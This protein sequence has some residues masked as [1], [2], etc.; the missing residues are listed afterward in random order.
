MQN[1]S[2]ALI[3]TLQISPTIH[4]NDETTLNFSTNQET[5][6]SRSAGN[7]LKHYLHNYILIYP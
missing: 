1:T 6:E 4:M 2:I 3:Q 5:I 7:H